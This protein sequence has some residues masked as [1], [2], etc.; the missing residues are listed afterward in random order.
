MSFIFAET[1]LGLAQ[2]PLVSLEGEEEIHFHFV[3]FGSNL[4]T[5][6][7]ILKHIAIK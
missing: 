4:N 1:T 3:I 2:L 7:A 5:L 6:H